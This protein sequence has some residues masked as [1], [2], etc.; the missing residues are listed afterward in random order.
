M[1]RLGAIPELRNDIYLRGRHIRY[2]QSGPDDRRSLI[3]F[4]EV[5]EETPSLEDIYIYY[6]RQR[7]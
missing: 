5:V 1:E 3:P 6:E 4:A 7:A 2:L